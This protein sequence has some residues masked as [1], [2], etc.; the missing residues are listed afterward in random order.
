[1]VKILKLAFPGEIMLIYKQW[2]NSE[3]KKKKNPNSNLASHL[4]LVKASSHNE[5]FVKLAHYS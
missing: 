4:N 5:N 3:K 1:M 2:F